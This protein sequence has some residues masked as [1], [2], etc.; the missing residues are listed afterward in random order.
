MRRPHL[1]LLAL[2]LTA[3]GQGNQPP[4]ADVAAAAGPAEAIVPKQA[5][6]DYKAEAAVLRTLAMYEEFEKQVSILHPADARTPRYVGG[7]ESLTKSLAVTH[8]LEVASIADAAKAIG[9][10]PPD[11]TLDE[12]YKG[13]LGMIRGAGSTEIAAEQTLI[14][15]S[16]IQEVETFLQDHPDTPLRAWAES[17]LVTLK[18]RLDYVR[19]N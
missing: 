13:Y 4:S 8:D 16:T 11:G 19:P 18:T 14:H 10:P 12:D 3:C 17:F 2:A 7:A 5:P 9:L 15:T 6:A 1:L